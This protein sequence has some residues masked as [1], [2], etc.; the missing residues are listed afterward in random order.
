MP[1][2]IRVSVRTKGESRTP[3]VSVSALKAAVRDALDL[4][5]EHTVVIQELACAEA[6]CPPVETVIAVF[7]PNNQSR[8]WTLHSPLVEVTAADIRTTLT[9]GDDQ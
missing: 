4:D 2:R 8:R 6:D 5:A 7:S 1:P 9:Q 3:A